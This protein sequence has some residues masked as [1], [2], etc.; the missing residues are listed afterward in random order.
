MVQAA[1]EGGRPKSARRACSARSWKVVVRLR[2]PGSDENIRETFDFPSDR[3]DVP[4]HS[5]FAFASAENSMSGLQHNYRTTDNDLDIDIDSRQIWVLDLGYFTGAG[6]I[7]REELL[8]GLHCR[9]SMRSLRS[10]T[11]SR[12]EGWSTPTPSTRYS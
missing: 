9:C 1:A 2:P 8:Y 7:G 4:S 6:S 12:V 3:P 10:R 11:H 5:G